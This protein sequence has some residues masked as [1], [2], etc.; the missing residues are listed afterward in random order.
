M[1]GLRLLPA[2]GVLAGLVALTF[3]C[4]PAAAPAPTSESDPFAVVRATSQAAYQTGKTLLDRGDLQGCPYIDTAK[5]TDPDNRSD[6]QQALDQCLQAIV[7][8]SAS[9]A[10][11]ATPLAA[12]S[13]TISPATAGCTPN[14]AGMGV[15]IL[16]GATTGVQG[17]GVGGAA[18]AAGVPGPGAGGPSTAPAASP[19]GSGG[20][21]SL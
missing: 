1:L 4:S 14:P 3:A 20:G 5:T 19:A 13:A 18:Q 2:A 7:A 11:A 16:G 17:A 15:M 8:Q 6:I 10:A 9:T 21:A 12:L